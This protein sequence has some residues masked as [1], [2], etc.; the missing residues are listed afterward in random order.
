MFT[1]FFSFTQRLH[2]ICVWES[3]LQWIWRSNQHRYMYPNSRLCCLLAFSGLWNGILE[4]LFSI[5]TSET[6]CKV[7][8]LMSKRINM[9]LAH[10]YIHRKNVDASKARSFYLNMGKMEPSAKLHGMTRGRRLIQSRQDWNFYIPTELK[11]ISHCKRHIECYRLELYSKSLLEDG[12]CFTD[13]Q[14]R[15]TILR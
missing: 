14:S 4:P 8:N 3:R 12:G 1:L 11:T 2:W 10:S 15:P 7:D 6:M 5:N 9:L 13:L